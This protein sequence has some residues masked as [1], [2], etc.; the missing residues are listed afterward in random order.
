[1]LTWAA[2]DDLRTKAD[3]WQSYMAAATV[4]GYAA[5]K[6]KVCQADPGQGKTILIILCA[7]YLAKEHKMEVHVVSQSKSIIRQ[8]TY[9]INKFIEADGGELDIAI[10][11]I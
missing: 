11:D 2:N 10:E 8:L 9:S 7:F 6:W 4:Y 5:G 3:W 1:M